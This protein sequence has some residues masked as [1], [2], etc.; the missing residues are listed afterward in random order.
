MNYTKTDLG[1][2][3]FKERSALL[4]ARQRSA[5]IMF[6]GAKTAEQVL[7]ATAGLGTTQAD[8]EHMLAQGFLAAPQ[9]VAATGGQAPGERTPVQRY[10]AAY[11]IATKLTA[12]LGLRGFTLNLAVEAAS[13]YDDLLALLPRIR[14]AVGAASAAELERALKS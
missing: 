2:Q 11:P 5:F 4:T 7:A 9:G 14:D 13:G 1:Q 10:A 12:A 3:A 8:L 6:D